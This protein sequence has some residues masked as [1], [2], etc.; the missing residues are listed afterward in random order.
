[1]KSFSFSSRYFDP[2]VVSDDESID[3]NRHSSF[4]SSSKASMIESLKNRI[5]E[6]KRLK[7]LH[8]IIEQQKE[9]SILISRELRNLRFSTKLRSFTR[10]SRKDEK[11]I[12][13]NSSSIYS[14]SIDVKLWILKVQN[15][16]YLQN[17][18]NSLLQI[19]CVISYFNDILK[20]RIQRLRLAEDIRFFSNW[21]NLQLW[22]TI[23]YDRQS[24]KLNADL[25]MKKIKM[26]EEERMHD[27]INKFETIVADLNWNE[28]AICSTFKKKLNRD[29][30]DTVHL[31]HS[32]DW[33]KTFAVFK[34]L[35]HDAEN[36]LR[37]EKRAYEKVYN[38]STS[39]YQKRKRVR[40]SS[41]SEDSRRIRNKSKVWS[42]RHQEDY[43]I[44]KE[45]RRR[46][47]NNLCLNCDEKDH[48]AKD[49]RCSNKSKLRKFNDSKKE[50]RF[51]SARI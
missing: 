28:S 43:A 34:T 19:T 7:S 48:W 10:S 6:L 29:I 5:W 22:L 12:K 15:F 17:I 14:L 3:M 39:D 24:A 21:Q 18:S 45:R 2:W 37:I 36:H 35:T 38:S 31:L 4:S 32:K 47:E 23:N 1:M 40:F 9:I 46:K 51:Q 27:F 33:S 30:L 41:E 20:R 13:V 16:F 49:S 11:K 26:K 8:H 42:N 50:Q 44:K 25:A